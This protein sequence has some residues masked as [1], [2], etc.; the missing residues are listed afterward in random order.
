MMQVVVMPVDFLRLPVIAVIG[1]LFY[2]EP[3]TL[4]L[5]AGAAII[6]SANFINI[7]AEAVPQRPARSPDL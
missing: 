2:D 7:R 4:A 1:F 5:V 6:I 3:V